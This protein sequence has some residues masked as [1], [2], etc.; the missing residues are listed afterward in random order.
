MS[1]IQQAE[2]QFAADPDNAAARAHVLE[3]IIGFERGSGRDVSALESVC[4]ALYGYSSAEDRAARWR[5][6]SYAAAKRLE[7]MLPF[8]EAIEL[9]YP[10]RVALDWSRKHG[11]KTTVSLRG[12]SFG[13]KYQSSERYGEGDPDDILEHMPQIVAD[14]QKK[15]AASQEVEKMID[16]KQ[17]IRQ[18]GFCH[19][20]GE[21][22]D[23]RK[24]R[25]NLM[26]LADDCIL[27]TLEKI[28][29]RI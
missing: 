16:A 27:N 17:L 9:A 25:A 26:P 14:L 10:V 8:L 1:D 22:N 29:A 28:R 15:Y 21:Y 19:F 5:R 12:V 20:P 24:D 3:K 7:E 23:R 2:A 4:D 6:R 18:G 11:R 13:P